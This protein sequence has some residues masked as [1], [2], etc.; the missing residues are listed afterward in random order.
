MTVCRDTPHA[1]AISAC[2]RFSFRYI[3]SA[4]RRICSEVIF[5]IAS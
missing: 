4:Q 2:V 5:D 1:S 3:E